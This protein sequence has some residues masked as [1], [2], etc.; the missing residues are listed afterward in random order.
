MTADC[1]VIGAGFTGLATA[2]QLARRKPDW[3]I[4]VVEAQSA[5]FS[6][7]GRNSGL[8]GAL[9]HRDAD[10]DLEGT[11]RVMRLCRAGIEWLS[12]R[13]EEHRIDCD[14]TPCGRIHAGVEAH[15]LHNLEGLLRLLDASAQP[16]DAMSRSNLAAAIGTDHYRAAVHIKDT[17]LLQPAALARGL[18]SNLPPNVELFEESPV[19]AMERREAWHLRTSRGTVRAGKVFLTVNGFAPALGL[20]KRRVFPLFTF[21]SLTRTLDSDEQAKVGSWDQ[22]GLVSEYRAGA[23]L[24]RTRDQRLLVRSCLRYAPALRV[25]DRARER[26]RR[27]HRRAL[28]ARWP[29]LEGV[30]FEFTW[31]GVM[32]MTLNQGLFFGSLDHELYASGGYNGTGVALG[33]A[34]GRLLAD[35]AL[36][37]DSPLLRDARSLPRPSWLPPEPLLG[38]G[39][40]PTIAFLRSRA[41]AEG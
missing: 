31:G 40:R 6:A 5:G 1:V 13:V 19:E 3:R 11:L 41:G 8:A 35:Y 33:T 18:A 37:A 15:A 32:G 17:V 29:A 25:P 28:L 23:T 2:W 22:W 39:V 36:G 16:Y 26:V 21:A 9:S 4:V 10:L 12:S 14:W 27:A 38:L 24:R 30:E 20:L 34:C 7:S